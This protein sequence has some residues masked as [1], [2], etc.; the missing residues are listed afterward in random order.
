MTPGRPPFE[1]TP[2]RRARVLELAAGGQAQ[3]AIAQQLGITV[4]TLARHFHAEIA[5]AR[6]RRRAEAEAALAAAE[7][8]VA[9]AHRAVSGVLA[10]PL[11]DT[12]AAVRV[13][14]EDLAETSGAL[15]LALRT[16]AHALR[17]LSPQARREEA[18]RCSR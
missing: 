1:A 14:R 11:P 13:W 18:R 6:A 2:S 7:A 4:P 3:R 8:A 5:D 12:L 10:W 16:R 9:A 17:S 15:V